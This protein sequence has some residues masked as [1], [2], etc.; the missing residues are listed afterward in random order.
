METTNSFFSNDHLTD[1][2]TYLRD[3]LVSK[4]W[5]SLNAEVFYSEADITVTNRADIELLKSL[6]KGNSRRRVRLCA[7]EN[8][9]NSLHEMVIVHERDT[10]VRPHKHLGKSESVH[11]IEGLVDVVIFDDGGQIERVICMGDYLSGK[12]FYY[13]ISTPS[14]HTLI[15]RSDFVVFHETTSGPFDRKDTVFASWA[16]DHV[17]ANSSRMFMAELNNQLALV[18]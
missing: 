11:I 12:T 8:P 13:R 10:Y 16:P 17:D 2:F 7:H 6:S 18:K 5:Y 9:E 15:I 14:F 4:N 1:Q 3:Q